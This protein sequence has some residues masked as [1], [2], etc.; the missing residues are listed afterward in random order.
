MPKNT[1]ADGGAIG[2]G[3]GSTAG[4]IAGQ[5]LIPIPGV[6]AAIGGF[7][8]GTAG[9]FFGGI[10]GE[11]E[12][13]KEQRL[14]A[15]R[16]SQ[17][18]RD[19]AN[20]MRTTG[21]GSL[22]MSY[23]DGGAM[24]LPRELLLPMS[25]RFQSPDLSDV[26]LSQ[27]HT[28]LSFSPDATGAMGAGGVARGEV[29]EGF[30]YFNGL[31]S[32]LLQQE[33]GGNYKAIGP[34]TRYGRALGRYQILP[35][36]VRRWGRE[37]TGRDVTTNEFLD[38]PQL[39]DQIAQGKLRQI[40]DTHL[41]RTGDPYLAFRMA[42]AEWYSGNGDN[43]DD[44]SEGNWTGPSRGSYVDQIA[45]RAGI[46][47]AS[48]I[49]HT[50]AT[51]GPMPDPIKLTPAEIARRVRLSIEAEER[52]R[53]GA[54]PDTFLDNRRNSET[55]RFVERRANQAAQQ[56]PV[57][58]A[59]PGGVNLGRYRSLGEVN[60]GYAT[61]GAVS[62]GED[63]LRLHGPSHEGGGVQL[64]PGHEAEGGETVDFLT[65]KG[66]TS[67]A[68]T[69]TPYIFSKRL[70]V[71]GSNLNF[72]QVHEQLVK[73]KAGDEAIN[74]LA[75][76]Q[77]QV[78]GRNGADA[79]G[80]YAI[81]GFLSGALNAAGAWAKSE[82]GKNVLS[83]GLQML[84]SLLNV[85]TAAFAKNGTPTYAPVTVSD[86]ALKRVEQTPT[87][88]DI[89]PAL[90][91]NRTALS[92]LVRQPGVSVAQARSAMNQTQANAGKMYAEKANTEAGL[93]ARKA[94]QAASI[95]AQTE[96]A[97][98]SALN[99]AQQINMENQMG[100]DAARQNMLMQGLTG[101]ANVVQQ[102]RLENE[103]RDMQR[104]SA[105][106]QWG[107]VSPAVQAR[108]R[109]ALLALGVPVPEQATAEQIQQAAAQAGVS[110]A[111]LDASLGLPSTN[112]PRAELAPMINYNAAGT[113]I[114]NFMNR[115]Q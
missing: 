77:E 14:S 94:S 91:E 1:Y 103:S 78:S 30:D 28:D 87:E 63:A 3:I 58:R 20:A 101:M 23:A 59:N 111:D 21:A 67:R 12:K 25:A 29:P 6:G 79:N 15:L 46:T 33:S 68:S 72:A 108:L 19:G 57:N 13:E 7:L 51:G 88:I 42:A 41:N 56:A 106:L 82:G 74:E 50:Y 49:R 83:T 62:I 53:G 47:P 95:I 52:A 97:N 71:P 110:V 93:E 24:N 43:H 31:V 99:Q 17:A 45:S 107:S 26:D 80:E 113:A 112:M 84:P 96:G 69:G 11:S 39:Q 81:G 18:A 65:K 61:G 38:N 66:Q 92:T 5:A 55:L 2:E 48:D 104:A 35:E 98:A 73:R 76:L 86:K 32:S 44:Y 90:N 109:P 34:T 89:N 64:A 102:S 8:G 114:R 40:Y 37:V 85:G 4:A 22:G 105:L 70:T 100:A 16:L 9:K 115:P 60:T 10:F 36:N 27:G 54:R 75:N